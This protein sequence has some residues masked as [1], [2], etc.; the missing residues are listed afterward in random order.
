MRGTRLLDVQHVDID[1]AIHLIA[2]LLREWKPRLR[3]RASAASGPNVVGSANRICSAGLCAARSRTRIANA[4]PLRNETVAP[5]RASAPDVDAAR[6][7]FLIERSTEA[8]TAPVSVTNATLDILFW[9]I[10]DEVST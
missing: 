6:N 8:P 1:D 2:E 5:R 3:C 4:L 9:Q 10:R 7:A